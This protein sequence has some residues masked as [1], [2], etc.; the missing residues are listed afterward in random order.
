MSPAYRTR[1]AG[2]PDPPGQLDALVRVEE[3][4]RPAAGAVEHLPANR[5]RA[6]PDRGD[7]AAARRVAD[8][9]PRRPAPGRGPAVRVHH[10]RLDQPQPAV[11]GE[12][13]GQLGQ[14]VVGRAGWRRRRGRT[15]GPR[16]RAGRRRCGRP[17]CPRFSGSATARTPSGRPV[18]C[19]PLPTTTTSSS[20][21][22]LRQQRLAA[23][24]PGPAAA[25]PGSAPRR[26]TTG[27]SRS[28]SPR[29]PPR[30]HRT[31]FEATIADEVPDDRTAGRRTTSADQQP[32]G[33]RRGRSRPP[34]PRRRRPGRS[35]TARWS[36]RSGG[37]ATNRAARRSSA[38]R[39]RAR[40][41][42]L[43][44]V[45]HPVHPG[46]ARAECTMSFSALF[47]HESRPAGRPG[48]TQPRPSVTSPAPP[49]ARTPSASAIP[50]STM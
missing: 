13:V 40:T 49:A 18:G 26:R 22:P 7:V 42:D 11:G 24:G 21:V 38:S 31:R 2:V 29:P 5:H 41:R 50:L 43:L 28:R 30:R 32:A 45:G 48:S 35:A 8:P 10:P 15:A 20:H 16:A 6:L 1:A 36:G 34:R 27:S 37:T 12:P 39:P 46:G 14:H 4:L 47:R 3:L 25:G 9:Q 33:W 19:Q 17:G 44:G 23:P